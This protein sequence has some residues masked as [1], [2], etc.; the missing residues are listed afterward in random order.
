MMGD[1]HTELSINSDASSLTNNTEVP[2][3]NDELRDK[4]IDGKFD[5]E[6]EVRKYVFFFDNSVWKGRKEVELFV[7]IIFI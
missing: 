2:N 1:Q 4:D 7:K 5:C 6:Y 3:T